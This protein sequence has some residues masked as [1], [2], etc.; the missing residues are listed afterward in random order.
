MIIERDA[1]YFVTSF[2]MVAA[3]KAASPAVVDCAVQAAHHCYFATDF[4]SNFATK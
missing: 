1:A 2:I 4:A 3:T